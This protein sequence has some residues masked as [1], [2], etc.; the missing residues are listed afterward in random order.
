[1]EALVKEEENSAAIH[2]MIIVKL[3][4]LVK[5]NID[6]SMYTNILERALS[7]GFHHSFF[8]IKFDRVHSSQRL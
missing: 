4:P 8:K 7:K 1:M 6:T 2:G 3:S 5:F